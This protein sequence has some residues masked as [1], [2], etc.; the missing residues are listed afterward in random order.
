VNVVTRVP[1]VDRD[2]PD[3]A[4]IEDAARVLLEGGLVAFATETVYGLGALATNAEAVARIFEAK[5]RPA[6]N[7]LIVHVNDLQLAQS[8]VATWPKE[9][10]TLA[11]RFWPGPLTLVLPRSARIPDVV[12]AGLDTVGVRMPAANVALALIA[13][14]G[15]PLAAPS[16]NRS[17]GISPTR[18]EHVKKDLD[19][20]IEMI[21]DSG[22][23][24]IG[25]ESTVLDLTGDRP[26]LLRPGAIS[27][28]QLSEALGCEVSLPDGSA[29]TSATLTSPGQ[30]PV[31]Y[32]PRTPTV[33]VEADRLGS[34][35]WSGRRAL[36]VIGH[37]ELAAQVGPA[38]QHHLPSPAEAARVLYAILHECDEQ[39][40]DQIVIVPPPDQAE[41][42]AV[43]DRIA[44]ASRLLAD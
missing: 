5:G 19:G 39:G 20:R 18:A 14:V 41:W 40:L 1:I 7:P 38:I 42:R 26:R 16:A 4:A 30:L 24:E 29:L 35:D 17:S 34:F 11:K 21:L 12:T 13:A 15:Q 33:C 37:P 22:P 25:M 8:C 32:A 36:L 23:T 31:H 10:G 28:E 43:R 3:P 6:R 27:A 9:A 2:A 44:R